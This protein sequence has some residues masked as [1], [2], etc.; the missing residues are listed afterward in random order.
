MKITE[1]RLAEEYPFL[2]KNGADPRLVCLL[3]DHDR[4][5]D[6]TA[7]PVTRP[8]ILVVPGGGYTHYGPMEGDP[9]AL[10]FLNRG[11]QAFIL[12]YSVE[13]HHFPQQMLEMASAMDYLHKNA[14]ILH[15]D[16]QKIAQIGFSAGGHMLASYATLQDAPEVREHICAVPANAAILCYP[17]VDAGD[18]AQRRCLEKFVGHLLSDEENERFSPSLHVGKNTPPTFLWHTA[19]DAVVSCK[20]SIR[21]ASALIDAGIRTE[22]HIYPEGPHALST[23]TRQTVKDPHGDI[24]AAVSSWVDLAMRFLS[25]LFA[26]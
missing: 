26:L 7:S 9:V 12:Y 5:K 1:V 25:Q 24:A 15:I 4:I 10:E 18:G 19:T 13:P 8:A 16:K 20:N 17:V 6:S 22:L 14:D 23:A 2:A 3:Q 11:F 21:Y